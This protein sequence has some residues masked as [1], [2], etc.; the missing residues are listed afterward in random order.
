MWERT[1]CTIINDKQ[2]RKEIEGESNSET[3][4]PKS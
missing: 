2:I 1:W 4:L 3:E